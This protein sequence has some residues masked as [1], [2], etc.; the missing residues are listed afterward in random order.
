M[1]MTKLLEQAF[2]EI[3]RLPEEDQ[4]VIAQALIGLIPDAADDLQWERLFSDP[5][6]EK[7]LE[8]LLREADAEIARGD[9]YDTNPGEA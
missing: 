5:R 3:S 6:S 9:V 1:N 4:D 7:A 8:H 2:N